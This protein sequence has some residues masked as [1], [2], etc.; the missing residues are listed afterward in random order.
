M[1]LEYADEI[2]KAQL[3]NSLTYRTEKFDYYDQICVFFTPPCIVNAMSAKAKTL[4]K[5]FLFL[6]H[7]QALHLCH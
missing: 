1:I 3:N 4:S 6:F 7:T 2:G 5:L